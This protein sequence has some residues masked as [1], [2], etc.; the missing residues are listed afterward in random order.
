LGNTCLENCADPSRYLLAEN[1]FSRILVFEQRA[2][3][4]G[5]WNYTPCPEGVSKNQPVPQTSPLSGFEE[6]VWTSSNASDTSLTPSFLSPI[7][8]QLESNIPLDL[9][10]F[11]DLP[12]PEDTQLFPTRQEVQSYIEQYSQDV[13][14][15]IQFET[16]VV[17]LQKSAS[18]GWDL[19]T[20]PV[21]QHDSD[22]TS[23]RFD[24]VIIANGH[25]NVPYIPEVEGIEAFNAAHPEVISH[26]RFYRRPERFRNKKVIIVGNSA[27]GIDIA[28]QIRSYC[29]ES[30]II[31]TRSESYLGLRGNDRPPIAKFISEDRAVEF[32]D[33]S[34]DNKIDA[35]LYCTG[36]LY[37]FPFI[38]HLRPPVINT[39]E[40]VEN[41]YQ[42]LFY[43]PDPTIAFIGLN[44][45]IIPFPYAEAQAAIVA[46]IFSGRLEV[47][48]EAEMR[49][50][51]ESVLD[52]MGHGK[53]F[54]VQ[55]FPKDAD[56][57]NMMHDWA[58]SADGE[59]RLSTSKKQMQQLSKDTVGKE[60]PY[61]GEKE[62][63]IRE[64]FPAI[65]LAFHEIGEDR[66]KVKSMAQIGFDFDSWKT[67]RLELDK[68][69]KRTMDGR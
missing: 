46:R 38:S 44:S 23:Y 25:F 13:R 26:S 19:T 50:W 22:L 16:Q 21:T 45:K 52:E 31:S 1:S 59:R 9:M 63:W 6:P 67:E 51:E 11:S 20:K 29:R 69:K 30:V 39:G 34:R 7:Y 56:Q 68:L 3:V 28:R 58:M 4:G 35:V 49:L 40:R 57:I 17:E 43:R 24:S 61:W 65:K 55:T 66:H 12:W 14:H 62:Y 37:S 27:S 64:R 60:P 33:G 36:Y 54:H 47:P 41:L 53:G 2:N 48:A 42:H 10:K 5:L 32:E 8:D 18:S 15:L